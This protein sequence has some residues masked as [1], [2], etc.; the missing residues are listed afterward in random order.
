VLLPRRLRQ[1]RDDHFLLDHGE[2]KLV[3]DEEDRSG[4]D[5]RVVAKKESAQP[6]EGGNEQSKFTIS[7]GL[8]EFVIYNFWSK[9]VI[10][11]S[12]PISLVGK[13]G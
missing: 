6:G 11:T 2:G 7:F 3:T 8:H 13:W 10:P 5:P 9:Y 12:T 4:D 1:D